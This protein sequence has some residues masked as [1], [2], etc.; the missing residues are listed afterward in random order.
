MHWEEEARRAGHRHGAGRQL[1]GVRVAEEHLHV[2]VGR[3]VREYD[4][5]SGLS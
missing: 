3:G 2:P 4:S 5:E 1:V